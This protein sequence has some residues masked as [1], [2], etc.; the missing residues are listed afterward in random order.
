MPNPN[1]NRKLFQ[2]LINRVNLFNSS[3]LS[4]HET[5]HIPLHL[6]PP[7][8]YS[9]RRRLLS[10]RRTSLFFRPNIHHHRVTVTANNFWSFARVDKILSVAFHR[11]RCGQTHTFPCINNSS[12]PRQDSWFSLQFRQPHRS[13]LPGLSN[14]VSSHCCRLQALFSET[15][16]PVA[17]RN[18]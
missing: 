17:E 15:R 4:S 11:T 8:L 18:R 14:T 10:Y 5:N 1:L 12:Q 7:N 3:S 16:Y 13:S 6:T 2:P 9:F